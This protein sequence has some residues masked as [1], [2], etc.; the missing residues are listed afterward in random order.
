MFT[1]TEISLN[2]DHSNKGKKMVKGGHT[3]GLM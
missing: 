2:R 1:E 3:S